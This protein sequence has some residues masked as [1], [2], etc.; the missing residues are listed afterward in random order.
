MPGILA[1]ERPLWRFGERRARRVLRKKRAFER[2]RLGILR[3]KASFRAGCGL[4]LR[5][6][7]TGVLF[8][9][10]TV[11]LKARTMGRPRPGRPGCPR[12][13]RFL[14]KPHQRGQSFVEGALVGGLV[15][16]KEGESFF[17]HFCCREALVLEAKGALGEPEGLG[18][19][20]NEHFFGR[21]GGLVVGEKGF[22]KRFEMGGVFA[23][24]Q[25]RAGSESV[26]ERIARRSQFALGRA[27]AGGVE[28]VRA[29]RVYASLNAFA[30]GVRFGDEF[31][32]KFVVIFALGGAAL[33]ARLGC[34]IEKASGVSWIEEQALADLEISTGKRAT[35]SAGSK[36]RG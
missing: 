20:M 36:F 24:Y 12:P 25:E 35:G 10:A 8:Q 18:H 2:R 27:R 29:V 17:V 34:H 7:A 33:L 15:A 23:G 22:E 4:R 6:E 28:G 14:L 31:G 9:A 1:V 16:K 3:N 13:V 21:I 11:L 5:N 32:R 26:F 19:L 30:N